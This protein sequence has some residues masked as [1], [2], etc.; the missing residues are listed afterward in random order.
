MATAQACECETGTL[1][2][3]Q[4]ESTDLGMDK[5]YGE[6]SFKRCKRC[7]RMWLR[8]YYVQEAFTGSGRWYEGLIPPELESSVTADNALEVLAK[9]DGYLCGGSWYDGKIIKGHG[10]PDLFP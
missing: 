7:Q 9:L 2:Y 3:D 8:Y 5:R 10:P 4:F 1:L 6:V